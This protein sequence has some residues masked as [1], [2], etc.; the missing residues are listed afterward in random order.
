MKVKPGGVVTLATNAAA[1]RLEYRPCVEC[2]PKLV[3]DS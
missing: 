3:A 2:N 1:Q